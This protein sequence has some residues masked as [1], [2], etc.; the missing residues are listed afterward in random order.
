MAMPDYS[1]SERDLDRAL[2]EVRQCAKDRATGL[3]KADPS[4]ANATDEEVVGKAIELLET[5]AQD[6][7]GLLERRQKARRGGAG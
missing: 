6:M 3:I 7:R 4:R 2:E 5:A 1:A